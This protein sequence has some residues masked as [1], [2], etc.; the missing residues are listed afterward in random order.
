MNK[1]IYDQKLDIFIDIIACKIKSQTKSYQNYAYNFQD[2]LQIEIIQNSNNYYWI[3]GWYM[4]TGVQ[5]TFDYKR[6]LHLHNGILNTFYGSYITDVSS[7][8]NNSNTLNITIN[9]DH[10]QQNSNIDIKS[11]RRDDIISEL[12]K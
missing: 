3:N 1:Y 5:Y 2:E 11:R 9:Y 10:L 7:I 12:L 8:Y 6:T 4:Q